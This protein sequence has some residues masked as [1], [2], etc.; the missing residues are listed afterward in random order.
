MLEMWEVKWGERKLIHHHALA[1]GGR[2]GPGGCPPVHLLTCPTVPHV[3]LNLC[4]KT[5]DCIKPSWQEGGGRRMI[6]V[7]YKMTTR[8][9]FCPEFNVHNRLYSSYCNTKL[10]GICWVKCWKIF[11]HSTKTEQPSIWPRCTDQCIRTIW[12]LRALKDC[13]V[14]FN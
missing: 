6:S 10:A 12:Q 14:P 11:E 5:E 13:R 2:E 3:Q 8:S 1:G 9:D 4:V 7:L